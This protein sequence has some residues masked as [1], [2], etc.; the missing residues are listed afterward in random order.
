MD[1]SRRRRRRLTVNSAST[2]RAVLLCGAVLLCA[3]SCSGFVWPMSPFTA[4]SARQEIRSSDGRKST[5]AATATPRG[6][7]FAVTADGGGASTA[8]VATEGVRR[9]VVKPWLTKAQET[10]DYS[11]V[12]AM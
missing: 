2:S 7:L 5:A 4:A 1:E 9:K 12:E 3:E 11:N 10:V 8:A 6:R